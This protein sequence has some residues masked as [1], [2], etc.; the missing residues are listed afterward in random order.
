MVSRFSRREEKPPR[1]DSSE[2]RKHLF[3]PCYRNTSR[4]S[5]V[6][7]GSFSLARTYTVVCRNELRDCSL[8]DAIE[9]NL[10]GMGTSR[11]TVRDS[12]AAAAGPAPDQTSVESGWPEIA[13]D[14]Y[15][16]GQVV[17][18][19]C[20]RQSLERESERHSEIQSII[21]LALFATLLT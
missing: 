7:G 18:A 1:K 3:C 17:E 4:E 20:G 5:T 11:Q 10:R 19:R 8:A 14:R 9:I 15:V 21:P 13:F 12:A 16:D 2:Q 6:Q